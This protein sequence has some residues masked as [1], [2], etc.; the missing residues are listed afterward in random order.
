MVLTQVE[1]NLSV[2]WILGPWGRSLPTLGWWSRRCGWGVLD[3]IEPHG[4]CLRT[5]LVQLTRAP[6]PFQD[7]YSNASVRKAVLDHGGEVP[8]LNTAAQVGVL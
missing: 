8:G 4:V 5:L 3:P 6:Q 1:G 2:A 7:P